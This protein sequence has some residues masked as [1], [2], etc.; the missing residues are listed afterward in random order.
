MS[1][2]FARSLSEGVRPDPIITYAEWADKNFYLPRESS[3]EYGRF[4][5]SRTPFVIEP[6]Y[7]L[8]PASSTQIV[9][10]V[11]PTQ[12]AGTTIGLIFLC[13]MMDMSPGPALFIGITDAKTRSFS[14]KKLS[15][16]IESSPRLKNKIKEAKSRDS[17]NTILLKEFPGGS[18]MLTGSNSGASYRTESIKYLVIDD[19]DGFAMDIEGEGSPEELADRRTG[20]FPNRKIYINSTTTVKD[21]SNIEIAFDKSSQGFFN[22]PCP[23]CEF[24]QYLQWGGPGEKFGIKFER[25]NDGIVTDA[26]YQCEQC[27]RPIDESYKTNI[28]AHGKYIHKYP[29][30]KTRGFRYNAF[31]TPSGWVNDWKYIS[32]KFLEA[33]KLLLRGNPSKMKTVM[34]HFFTLPYEEKGERP[35]WQNL[36]KRCEDYRLRTVP[37]AAQLVTAGVDTQDNRL[38]F[39]V[40]AWGPREESWLVYHDVLYGDPAEG[41]VFIE[42][43]KVLNYP[44]EHASGGKM[45]IMT[46]AIDAMGHRTQ[47]VYNHARRRYPRVMAIQGGHGPKIPILKPEPSKQDVTFDGKLIKSGVRLWTIGTYQAKQTIYSR[48]LIE[49]GIGVYHWPKGTTDEYFR[50]LTAEKLVKKKDKRGR[51]VQEWVK[52]RDNNEALDCEVYAY[53]AAL[54]SGLLVMTEHVPGGQGKKSVEVAKPR[55]APLQKILEARRGNFKRPEWLNR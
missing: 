50:Q 52:T 39:V 15:K 9:V 24:Y 19:F 32:Q 37:A 23:F 31:V 53:A 8:S 54:R 33:N 28:V 27:G 1:N 22:V 47:A 38:E 20:S 16:A 3:A 42:L 4:R 49:D 45:F 30:R 46:L 36:S 2:R 17:G 44:Y 35:E 11:K 5:S 51:F 48:L 13:G 40:R 21:L 12:L 29:D 7:E 41:K 6:L 43:D 25:D 14:K 26:W 10:V 18:L 34:N 55:E